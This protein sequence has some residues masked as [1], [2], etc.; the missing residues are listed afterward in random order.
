MGIEIPENKIGVVLRQLGRR[1]YRAVALGGRKGAFA[2]KRHIVPLTPT[3]RGELRRSWRALRR[4][5]GRRGDVEVAQ[6]LNDAPHAGIVEGGAR[7]HP[8]SA[9]GV[10]RIQGWVRRNFRGI[11]EREQNTILWGIV[12]KIREQGQA[13]T[14]FIENELMEFRDIAG[15]KIDEQIKQVAANPVKLSRKGGR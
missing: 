11:S 8:V 5:V 3:D 7:P 13:P 6:L 9:E 1:T 15:R 2:G 14:R 12:R 4:P 10:A